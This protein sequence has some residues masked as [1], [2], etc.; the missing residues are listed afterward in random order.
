MKWE[1]VGEENVLFDLSLPSLAF[2]SPL[3][4]YRIHRS[5]QIDKN[6]LNFSAYTTQE[7]ANE[8]QSSTFPK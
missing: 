2:P 4:F 3:R 1:R 5:G 6:G 7:N 8:L